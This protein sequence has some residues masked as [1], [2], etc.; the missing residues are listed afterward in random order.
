MMFSK[1]S[2]L[3][4]QIESLILSFTPKTKFN[5]SDQCLSMKML[6]NMNILSLLS[7]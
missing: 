4:D 6:V 1:H 2:N 3:N 5:V 7:Q